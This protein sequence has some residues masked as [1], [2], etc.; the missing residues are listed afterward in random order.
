MKTRTVTI[1]RRVEFDAG[2]RVPDHKSQC[3]NL[4]GHRYVLEATVTGEVRDEPGNPENGMITDFGELKEIMLTEVANEWD[5]AFLVYR[6]D[7]IVVGFLSKISGHKT[8]I[9]QVVPTAENLVML[10]AQK[11]NDVL[12][13]K[14]GDKIALTNL[15]LYETPNCWADAVRKG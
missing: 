3:R 2:H 13:A 14:Y 7:K 4:H 8:V 12:Q 10:A 9:L 11:I 5:H 6:N 1:T 15:R